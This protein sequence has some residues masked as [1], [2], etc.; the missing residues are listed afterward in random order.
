M[1]PV[2]VVIP[3][4]PDP[5]YLQ[6]L[7]ECIASV[8]DQTHT[9]DEIVFIDDGANLKISDLFGY[10]KEPG[11]GSE[12]YNAGY[13]NQHRYSGRGCGLT[14][15]FGAVWRGTFG[16][17]WYGYN[18]DTKLPNKQVKI[19]YYRTFWNVGVA[20]AFNFGIAIAENNLIF[21]LGS[22]DRML[23]TCLEECVKAYEHHKV[24]G[25]YNVTIETS[26]G[27]KQWIPNNTAMVT[28]NL[29]FHTDGFGPS[30]FAGPDAW[31]L[32]ILMHHESHKIIQVKQGTPLCWLREHDH[33]DTKK[34]AW[35]FGPE[36][37]SIRAKETERWKPNDD[38]S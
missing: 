7:P 37:N 33:Q 4:G 1:H 18:A 25:W 32:S 23:P 15:N 34:T 9:P 27:V 20:D 38:H 28:K 2:T 16:Y 29:W 3:V 19:R 14:D 10:C 24:E 5:V 31:L 26:G 35:V 17:G 22:D 6:W 13:Y 12:F 11:Y 30:A 36:M 21:T 8:M